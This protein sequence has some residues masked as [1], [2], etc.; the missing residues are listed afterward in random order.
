MPKV[1]L[2]DSCDGREQAWRHSRPTFNMDDLE[3]GEIGKM[4]IGFNS[5]CYLIFEVESTVLFRDFLFSI[6]PIQAWARSSR[7][8]PFSED[9]LQIS[10]EFAPEDQWM[11]D[12]ALD[13]VRDGVPQDIARDSLPMILKTYYTVGMD[14]RTV[15]GLIKTMKVLDTDLYK[16]YG[17]LFEAEV[18][19]ILGYYGNTVKAFDDVYMPD[20]NTPMGVEKVGSYI[21][22]R[23]DMKHPLASQFLRQS[24]AWVKTDIWY[25]I[26]TMGYRNMYG[27]SQKDTTG[28]QF[29]TSSASYH[30]LIKMRSHWF[31][32]WQ[33][34]MWGR[35]VGDYI[36]D[37]ST[38]EFWNFIP[39]GGGNEDPYLHDLMPRVKREDPNLPCPISLEYPD[40]V[41]E[42]MN[43]MGYNDV[44]KKYADLVAEGYIKDNPNNELRRQYVQGNK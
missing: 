36:R 23:Y 17:R 37:M 9:S 40:L 26:A 44:I 32:D 27:F 13:R 24:N 3:M 34:D 33:E 20:M 12:D 11:I 28:V 5:L 30:K 22:G 18:D 19:H 38:K 7:A 14:F 6:R 21:H 8:T 35:M 25:D 16:I 41:S 2:V 29:V 10:E 42:R 39:Q 43:T 15:C 4:D 31:A 1:T